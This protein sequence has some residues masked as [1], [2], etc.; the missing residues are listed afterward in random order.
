LYNNDLTELSTEPVNLLQSD[1]ST[2]GIV[3][4]SDGIS[5]Y[6][7]LIFIAYQPGASDYRSIEIPR[8]YFTRDTTSRYVVYTNDNNN[9]LRTM[10]VNYNSNA[11]IN[12][13]YVAGSVVLKAVYGIK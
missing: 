2:T 9:G 6:R 11:S 7:T 10:M 13:S 3:Q 5:N 8:I 12:I 4:L 1:V